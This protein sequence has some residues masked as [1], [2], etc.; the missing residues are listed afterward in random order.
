[1]NTNMLTEPMIAELR[2]LEKKG[3]GELHTDAVVALARKPSSA[4]HHHPAF[5]WDIEKPH[6]GNGRMRPGR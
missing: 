2:E 6:C 3:G 5:V 4:L 1:M